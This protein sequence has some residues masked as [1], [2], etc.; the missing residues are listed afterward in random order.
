MIGI[1]IAEA[2]NR[3]G[4]KVTTRGFVHTIRDQKDMLFIIIRD[5]TGYLQIT[6]NKRDK[7]KL[8]ESILADI[9]RESVLSI[10]GEMVKNPQVRL[11]EIELIAEK[12][13]LL[14]RAG[15]LL[16]ID[17]WAKNQAALD[18]RIDWRY[19]D[20]RS[21]KRRLIFEIQTE[22]E[23]EMREWWRKN[24]YI[25]IHS[26][27]LLGAPSESGSELFELKYFDETAYLAQSPQFYKQ[28]AMAAGFERVFEIG[29][30]F[31]ANPS[32][33]SRH[34]TEF[35]SIDMEISWISSHHDLMKIEEEWIR[36]IFVSLQ[37]KFSQKIEKYYNTSVEV[38]TTPFP[39]ITMEQA[40]EVLREVGH[41]FP[42][43][44]KEGDID[45]SGEKKLYSYIKQEYNHDF[46]F[47]YDYPYHLR[48]FYHM[49][50]I[51]KP[52]LTKSYD[53]LYR[54][55]EVTTGAQREH[56]YQILVEQANEKGVAEKSIQFYLDFFKYG[57]PPH[58]GYGFGLTRLIMSILGLPNVREVTYLYR[59]PNRLKP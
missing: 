18:R 39:K 44:T 58:G 32:F 15:E 52:H 6:I 38:P 7:D 50:H 19:L 26:P 3:A 49:K 29:P 59:G 36:H 41:I 14:S 57:M 2:K 17:P 5:R 35:T 27:K 28:M 20:L 21:E 56:R 46:V 11:D 25:E 55:L 48:P 9:G 23:H 34:D 24:N 16:P 51:D 43:N 1:S 12:Y 40:Q 53:L 37:E 13:E 10:T 22:I 33:T 42:E 30:V 8:S 4:C 47:V 54:G 31:R 45:P